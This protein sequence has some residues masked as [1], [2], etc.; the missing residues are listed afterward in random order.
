MRKL[1]TMC[2]LVALLV[3]LLATASLAKS[4]RG[5]NG[6]DVLRGT[7]K[8]DTI[9][10]FK[11]AD[12]VYGKDGRDVLRGNRGADLVRGGDG[13]DRVY[14]G[15]WKDRLYGAAGNDRIFAKDGTKDIV[16]CGP[17][18]DR[19][20]VDAKDKVKKCEI[21][22]GKKNNPPPPP[23]KPDRDEDGVPNDKDNCPGVA[24]AGQDDFDKDHKGDACDADIDNDG[25]P[26]GKDP[27]DHNPNVPDKDGDGVTDDKDNCLGVKNA[28]QNDLDKDKRGNACDEDI[29]GDGVNNDEDPAPYNPD[30]PAPPAM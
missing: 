14:G 29:D 15:L 19:A 18:R 16:R 25:V 17:G 21:V 10:A 12:K 23:E 9:R 8:A 4:E 20:V 22:N 1:T 24:N 28:N 30:V 2:V 13:T 27:D 6:P 5:T 11:G 7:N 26:N 3:A